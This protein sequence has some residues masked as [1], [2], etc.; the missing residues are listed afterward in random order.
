MLRVLRCAA[1]LELR[2]LGVDLHELS[3][4]LIVD[5][6]APT[7]A[8]LSDQDRASPSPWHSRRETNE[9]PAHSKEGT[10]HRQCNLKA[11]I[12]RGLG[13]RP[14]PPG[15]AGSPRRGWR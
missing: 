7:H 2:H 4:E 6:R 3:L 13:S 14:P 10:T 11:G 12:P 1:L 8:S 15:R 5:L 9:V